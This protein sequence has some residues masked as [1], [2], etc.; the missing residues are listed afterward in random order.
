MDLDVEAALVD[1]REARTRI[2]EIGLEIDDLEDE[3]A[4]EQAA[5]RE[6]LDRLAT[7]GVQP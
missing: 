5:L 2:A 4:E 3:L 7:L 6:A 1:V